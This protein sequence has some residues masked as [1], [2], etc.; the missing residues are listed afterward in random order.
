MFIRLERNIY[1]CLDAFKFILANESSPAIIRR[2]LNPDYKGVKSPLK[3]ED[4]WP[5]IAGT[6]MWT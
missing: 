1:M 5:P 3:N 4:G 6:K 2:R